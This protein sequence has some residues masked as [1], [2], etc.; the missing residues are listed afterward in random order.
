MD[1]ITWREMVDRVRVLERSLGSTQKLVQDNEAQTIVLQRRAIRLAESV[2]C[3][4]T[5]SVENLRFQRPC[6]ED[7]LSVNDVEK[8]LG[9]KYRHTLPAG[10]YLRVSDVDV[11]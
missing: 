4:E 6:P 10:E 5:V 2:E 3:G 9:K 7:A 8:I 1:P 11:E